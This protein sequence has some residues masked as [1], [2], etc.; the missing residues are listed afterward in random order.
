MRFWRQRSVSEHGKR[1]IAALKNFHSS[2]TLKILISIINPL[3]P[4]GYF[5]IEMFHLLPQ[6]VVVCFIFYE[7]N[8]YFLRYRVT[9]KTGTFKMRSGKHVQ[10]AT[11]RYRDLELHTTSPFSNHGSVERS[12]AC[13][14]F[15]F[16][17][18]FFKSSLFCVTLYIINTLISYLNSFAQSCLPIFL[19]GTLIFKGLAARRLY[20]SFGAKGLMG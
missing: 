4:S 17:W 13:C 11:L 1:H 2:P 9:Q 16:C 12:T 10:L 14:K 15:N 6:T 5:I 3:K 19:L 18:V 20:K 8:G 7:N